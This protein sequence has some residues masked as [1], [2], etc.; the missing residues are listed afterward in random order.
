MCLNLIRIPL[1][2]Q[3][4]NKQNAVNAPTLG[5]LHHKVVSIKWFAKHYPTVLNPFWL[6]RQPV[7]K[8]LAPKFDLNLLTDQTS[9]AA[10]NDNGGFDNVDS[11]SSLDTAAASNHEPVENSKSRDSDHSSLY[12]SDDDMMQSDTALEADQHVQLHTSSPH[13]SATQ[14]EIDENVPVTVSPQAI[15][16][17][18]SDN[19]NTTLPCARTPSIA[20]A[21]SSASSDTS[22]SSSASSLSTSSSNQQSTGDTSRKRTLR[23]SAAKA[24]VASGSQD[25]NT[26]AKADVASGSQENHTNI[27]RS[28][29]HLVANR[30]H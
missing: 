30:P 26:S 3:E 17:A 1:A 7:L 12:D 18:P 9:T 15:H 25:N 21:T 29:G 8:A 10:A 24:D 13:A 4:L 19:M 5:D 27:K 28:R 20:N 16:E 2:F 11:S 6:M 22:S 23:T 14:T